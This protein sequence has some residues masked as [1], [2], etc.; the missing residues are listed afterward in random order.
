[1]T[2][3]LDQHIIN[4]IMGLYIFSLFVWSNV[5]DLYVLSNMIG[6]VFIGLVW[7]E[8][9]LKNRPVRFNQ[10]ILLIV[11]EKCTT[12]GWKGH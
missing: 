1:M 8:T 11:N 6:I 7:V 12:Y 4:P 5:A 2:I 10:Y 3:K 9:L